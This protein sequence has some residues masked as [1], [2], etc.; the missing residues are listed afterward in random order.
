MPEG[1]LRL[2]HAKGHH[3]ASLSHLDHIPLCEAKKPLHFLLDAAKHKLNSSH[4]FFFFN[5]L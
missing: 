4:L 3:V 1:H 2:V 5:R